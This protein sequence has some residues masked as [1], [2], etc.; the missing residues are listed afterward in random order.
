MFARTLHRS[1][2]LLILALWVF[3]SVNALAVS[4]HVVLDSHHHHDVM[5]HDHAGADD[6]G[7]QR[8]VD[9]LA[10]AHRHEHG[11]GVPEHEPSA[12]P[13]RAVVYAPAGAFE[14]VA[15]A[16]IPVRAI[17]VESAVWPRQLDSCA[18]PPDGQLYS[19]GSLRL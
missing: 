8:T 5:G 6:S 16:L 11:D 4:V 17:P 3:P 9:L 15:L 13:A 2:I 10:V 7:H 18:G 14:F 19:I 1:W 12:T